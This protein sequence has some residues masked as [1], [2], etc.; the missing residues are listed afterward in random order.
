MRYEKLFED[1]TRVA[2]LVDGDIRRVL[3]ERGADRAGYE[4]LAQ[5]MEYS[6]F[7]GGKRVRPYLCVLFC[8]A[9][10]GDEASAVAYGA[11]VE[12][13]HTASLIHDDLPAMD[14]DDFRRGKPT[15]HKAFGEY[16]A[17]LAGDALIIESF[18]AAATNP[19]CDGTKNARAA[20]LLAECAGLDGMCGGQQLDLHIEGVEEDIGRVQKTHLLK[21]AA[22]IR[23]SACLGCIAAG[24]DGEQTSLAV[25]FAEDVGLAFQIKD[26]VLDVESSSET[27]GKTVGKDA[28]YG[29]NTYVSLLGLEDAKAAARELS[30]RAVETAQ[31][32]GGEGGKALLELCDYLLERRN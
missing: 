22:M 2:A 24:A 14:N 21:T 32:I 27:M 20:A 23:A 8:R 10:G 15:S 25:R 19:L 7:A 30:L 5:A 6:L 9:F 26:D 28:A 4:R 18:Y 11:A 13:M 1:M 3:S 16:T 31:K 29:K 17:I 12:M